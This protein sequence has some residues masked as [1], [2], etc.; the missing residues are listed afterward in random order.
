VEL[1]RA[2]RNRIRNLRFAPPKREK[3]DDEKSSAEK[4]GI[5]PI[6]Q[7]AVERRIKLQTAYYEDK[8]ELES[9]ETFSKTPE[10]KVTIDV[11]GYYLSLIEGL[12]LIKFSD[13]EN[14][15][16]LGK[17][18]LQVVDNYVK[19][20]NSMPG[21]LPQMVYH[22]EKSDWEAGEPE[23]SLWPLRK[24]S[25]AEG[26]RNIMNRYISIKEDIEA[27]SSFV[28]ENAK[29][30][31]EV[32]DARYLALDR[33]VKQYLE[34]IVADKTTVGTE[35][36]KRLLLTVDTS[37]RDSDRRLQ[38]ASRGNLTES[39][40][41]SNAS[42]LGKEIKIF[43]LN[44][45]T[46]TLH[47]DDALKS[48]EV[49]TEV[50]L[51]FVGKMEESAVQL[52]KVFETSYFDKAAE[53]LS[54]LWDEYA[55]AANASKR[56]QEMKF[57]TLLNAAFLFGGKRLGT[58]KRLETFFESKEREKEEEDKS[59]RQTI[60]GILKKILDELGTPERPGPRFQ[61]SFDDVKVDSE[62]DS[63]FVDYCDSCG[64]DM[65]QSDLLV[66]SACSMAYY[67]S[68]SCQRKH[69]LGHRARCEFFSE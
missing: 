23:A 40:M 54:N 7:L 66:C 64:L 30:S 67:C 4:L 9:E 1:V 31:W 5:T 27:L 58:D 51:E 45:E 29:E 33:R 24:S 11:R 39:K 8:L 50:V 34:E 37:R 48:L 3:R 6:E 10:P 19:P 32:L 12:N 53:V 43:E 13:V 20:V 2:Q 36:D 14:A 28:A 47:L 59:D 44:V 18:L 17:L 63:I 16:A 25:V 26:Y 52:Q 65:E 55:R 15:D 69:W 62:M 21:D 22:I 42:A 61:M 49:P 57:T 41:Q 38:L 46:Q 35:R 68:E 56:F 60:S